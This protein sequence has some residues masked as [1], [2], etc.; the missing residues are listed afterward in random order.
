MHLLS[1]ITALSLCG[2][3]SDWYIWILQFSQSF[4]AKQL[5]LCQI[6][7][8][9]GMNSSFQVQP[10][11]PNWIEIWALTWPLQNMH[12]VVFE[13]FLCSFCFM[14]EVIVLLE[15]QSSVKSLVD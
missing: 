9:S 6:A 11:I 15:K 5:K 14:L 12:L 10:Q 8:G 3:V 2:Y 4:H 7:W 13:P 1:A